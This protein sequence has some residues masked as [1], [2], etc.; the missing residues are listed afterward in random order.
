MAAPC[1]ATASGDAFSAR[2][3]AMRTSACESSSR[4]TMA[5]PCCATASGDAFSASNAALRTSASE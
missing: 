1:S 4:C 3:A 5:A 2:S